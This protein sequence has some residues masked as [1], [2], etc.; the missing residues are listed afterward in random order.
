V[1]AWEAEP[2]LRDETRWTPWAEPGWSSWNGMSPEKEFCEFVVQLVELT[3]PS[4]VIET[5]TGQGFLARRIKPRSGEARRLTCFES[6]SVWREAMASLPFFDGEQCVLSPNPTP[7]EAEFAG[8]G[9]SVLD[10]KMRF[11][12]SELETWWS[13]A[14][15]GAL[16]VVHDASKR[17]PPDTGHAMLARRITEL[18]IPGF[19]LQNPRGGFVGVK[20]G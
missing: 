3:R 5:G 14:A 4:E 12:P 9:V 2:P 16:V 6:D 1:D 8:A 20:P 19:F 18:G 15:S 17:H 13:S 7:S 11:R 10:S